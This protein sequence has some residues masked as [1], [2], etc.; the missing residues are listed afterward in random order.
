M[1]TFSAVLLLAAGTYAFRLAGP[2]LAQRVELTE[3]GREWLALPAVALLAALV[4]TATVFSAA[5]FA[6]WARTT[7]VAVAAVLALRRAPFVAVV[8]VAAA[9][10]AA[11][12][13]FGVP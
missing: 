8:V 11:L 9:V 12:R 2:L 4:A 10:T 1:L 6:G 3:T 13:A 7:G 5:E